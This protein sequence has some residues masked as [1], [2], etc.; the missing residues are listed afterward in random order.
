VPAA[1]QASASLDDLVDL[2]AGRSVTVLT[3]AGLS[4]ES[5]I[6]DYGGLHS[7]TRAS[8]IQYREFTDDPGARRRYWARSAVGW[9]RVDGAEPNAGHRALAALEQAMVVRGIIT[10]NVDGLHQLAGS[11]RVVDLHG[12]L[13]R[14]VCLSCGAA[15][16]R[17]A[18]Q[19]R[20]EEANPWVRDVGAEDAPDGDAELNDRRLATFRVPGCGDCGGTLKP[21]VVFFGESVPKPV[22]AE[23]W[24]LYEESEVLLV[25]GSSLAVFSGFRFVLRASQEG[26]PV[27]LVNLG[28]TRADDRISV[29]VTRRAGEVL[30]MLA[31]AIPRRS[32]SA[33]C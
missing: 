18:M 33:P 8:R 13:S 29:R 5:G 26:R 12:R 22:L 27:G 30:P 1:A 10:Q 9:R 17:R 11:R 4:T 14:V 20:L 16:D 21:D 31:D 15:G 19:Q 23:A 25:V 28:P 7:E 3:G 2:L 6:P 32:P 24:R